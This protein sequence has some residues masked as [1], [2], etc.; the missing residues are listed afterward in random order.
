MISHTSSTLSNQPI[1]DEI[2]WAVLSDQG[3]APIIKALISKLV[4]L[5]HVNSDQFTP[6]GFGFFIGDDTILQLCKG[7]YI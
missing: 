1:W 6:I 2:S 4:P 3:W 7:L 5:N